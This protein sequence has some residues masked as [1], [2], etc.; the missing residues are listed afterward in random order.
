MALTRYKVLEAD[1]QD[2]E[3]HIPEKAIPLGLWAIQ[4]ASEIG[5]GLL[6]GTT[7]PIVQY[8][9]KLAFIMKY[10]DWVDEFPEEAKEEEA[11]GNGS[12]VEEEHRMDFPH[13]Q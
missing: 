5:A 3:V 7:P 1:I 13:V 2:S 12:V 9:V 11:K 10:V 8:K 4:E 6:H